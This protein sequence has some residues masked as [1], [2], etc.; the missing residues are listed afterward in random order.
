MSFRS[1]SRTAVVQLTD[2]PA[3]KLRI[4]HLSWAFVFFLIFGVITKMTVHNPNK[5]Y[6]RDC[7]LKRGN[8]KSTKRIL[9]TLETL[10]LGSTS[11]KP[12]FNGK[13]TEF[14][15]RILKHRC[16]F[17]SKAQLNST[18]IIHE[19]KSLDVWT[20]FFSLQQTHFHKDKNYFLLYDT[21]YNREKN[22]I[23]S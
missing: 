19:H 23:F 9:L 4:Q 10:F 8:R 6:F 13:K 16:S 5:L 11:R 7:D 20:I 15:L 1:K 22:T 3:R 14:D 2:F 17:D 18:S 12:K 21:P